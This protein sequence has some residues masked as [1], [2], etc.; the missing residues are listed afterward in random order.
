MLLHTEVD[1]FSS[2]SEL[3][4]VMHRAQSKVK[5]YMADHNQPS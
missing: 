3:R 1:G 2:A 5:N 4:T